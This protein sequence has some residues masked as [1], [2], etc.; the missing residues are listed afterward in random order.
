VIDVVAEDE[1][2][3]GPLIEKC[4]VPLIKVYTQAFSELSN[5]SAVIKPP[6]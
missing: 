5:G 2:N 6:Q 4:N 1:V 3:I